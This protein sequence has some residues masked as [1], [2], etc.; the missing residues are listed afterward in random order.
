M[1]MVRVVA[2]G[3]CLKSFVLRLRRKQQPHNEQ[4]YYARFADGY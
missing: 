1:N 2:R 3:S 4:K